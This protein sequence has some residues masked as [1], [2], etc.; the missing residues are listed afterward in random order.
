MSD[1][2]DRNSLWET[3]ENYD[4]KGQLIINIRAL[5]TKYFSVVRTTVVLTDAFVTK[6]GVRQDV[7]SYL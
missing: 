3:L 7:C 6:T 1:R 4:L 5:Y 2:I